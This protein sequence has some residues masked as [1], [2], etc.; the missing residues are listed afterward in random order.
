MTL[1]HMT[2]YFNCGFYCYKYIL[3]GLIFEET[4][5]NKISENKFSSRITHYMVLHNHVILVTS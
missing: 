4:R 1:P 2:K 3:V 5:L